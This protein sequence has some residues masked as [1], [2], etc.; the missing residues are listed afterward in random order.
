LGSGVDAERQTP[1]PLPEDRD[2]TA[3]TCLR[4]ITSRHTVASPPAGAALALDDATWLPLDQVVTRIGSRPGADLQLD[5]HSVSPRH[6]LLISSP[7]GVVLLDDRSE[8]GTFVN[9]ERTSR[10]ILEPGDEV[11]VGHVTFRFCEAGRF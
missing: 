7:V 5:E 3:T 9:G 2:M 11:R 1:T 8:T 4:Y 10:T 6:A